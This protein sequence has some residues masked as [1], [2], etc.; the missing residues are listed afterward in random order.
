MVIVMKDMRQYKGI[1]RAVVEGHATQFRADKVTPY[2][3][4]THAV[5]AIV[6][7]WGGSVVAQIVSMS[8]DLEEDADPVHYD[9]WVDAVYGAMPKS[10]ATRVIRMVRAL[11]KPM[12][13][14]NRTRDMRNKMALQQIVDIE[15]DEP[16]VV[17]IKIADRLHNLQTICEGK[18]HTFLKL[19]LVESHE[20]YAVLAPLANKHGW[21]APLEM[22]KNKITELE[23]YLIES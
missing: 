21:G 10:E 7:L 5:T 11:T 12:R 13:A 18:D 22:L 9:M 15:P 16:E 3:T 8:H 23:N 4:H 17:L 20:L 1:Y 2:I 14:R 19:Y 6:N